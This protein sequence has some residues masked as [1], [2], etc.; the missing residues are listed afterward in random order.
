M[1]C[2]NNVIIYLFNLNNYYIIYYL[3]NWR[4][5]KKKYIYI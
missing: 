2:A 4:Y 5:L 1:E 3:L